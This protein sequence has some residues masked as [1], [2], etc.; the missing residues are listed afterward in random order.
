MKLLFIFCLF[1]LNSFAQQMEIGPIIRNVH[2]N[3][4][5]ETLKSGNTSVDSTFIYISD[6]L[7]L[8]F[9][10]DFSS[11]KFQLYTAQFNTPGITNQLFYQL[12]NPTNLV[13]FPV[14]ASFTNGATFKRTFDSTTGTFVDSV[15]TVIA[16]KVADF[17]SYPIN[18]QT[19]DLYPPYY[20]YDTIGV[21][22]VRDTVW[23]TNPTYIQDSA[24]V[25]FANLLDP[26]AL[27]LD[28]KAYL[29]ERFGVNPRSLGVVT[30]DGLK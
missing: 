9:Y 20:I 27:W 16:V 26:N 14:N 24:R 7:N 19:E 13:P 15:F 10:D 17:T 21:P 6:T 1:A 5:E 25:F 30:F 2:L 11:N 4:S 8:P 18:Y 29:N 28:H 12:L 3:P 22:D 23:L